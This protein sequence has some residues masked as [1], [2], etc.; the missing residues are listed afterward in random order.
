[1]SQFNRPAVG[2]GIPGCE[3]GPRKSLQAQKWRTDP[4]SGVAATGA[5]IGPANGGHT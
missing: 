2:E 1:M 3:N 5:E 4:D